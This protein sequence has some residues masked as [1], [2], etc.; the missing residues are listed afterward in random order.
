MQQH[1]AIWAKVE[2]YLRTNDDD[3]HM[4]KQPVGSEHGRLL[5]P[6][7]QMIWAFTHWIG[8]ICDEL[9]A[10]FA[11]GYD[12]VM[13]ELGGEYYD[14]IQQLLVEGRIPPYSE[15]QWLTYVGPQFVNDKL[16]CEV[17][18][19]GIY[20]KGAYQI[21]KTRGSGM[22]AVC[23]PA[24]YRYEAGEAFSYQN[25]GSALES[26]LENEEQMKRALLHYERARGIFA[27]IPDENMVGFMED[28]LARVRA[29]QES[30][31]QDALAQTLPKIS[32]S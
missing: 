26:P 8:V 21:K 19:K 30:T 4:A 5:P 6:A 29:Y 28:A 15:W 2:A 1:N 7:Q 9:G 32:G 23:S 31:R 22:L 13:D 16:I 17:Y 12:P 24:N 14:R 3:G 27:Q 18:D 20:Q 25:R 11:T 10:L